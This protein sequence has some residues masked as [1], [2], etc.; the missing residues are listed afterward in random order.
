MKI[1]VIEDDA[2]LAANLWD[3]LESR[4]HIIDAAGDG[5]SGLHLA[6]VNDYEAITLDLIL[7][8]LDGLEL[9]RRLRVDARNCTPVLM[10][11]ARDT[12][13]DKLRGFEAGADDYLVKPF[14]LKELEARLTALA[15]RAN[16]D[17]GV[18]L[19]QAAD[20]TF[21]LDTLLVERAGQSIT[22]T[23]TCLQ[24]LEVL[25]RRS[26]CVVPRGELEMALWGDQPPN[27]DALSYHI[28]ALRRAIDTPFDGHLL[29]TVRG[30]GYRLS[31]A[32]TIQT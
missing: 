21:D 13:G 17:A 25:M 29:Q 2:D 22:L 20:L 28:H 10:L 15:R 4:G 18:R 7:P 30:I 6:T 1:L 26:G 11:T 14:A 9:C 12:L 23:P 27:S 3:Y 24:I 8:R 32:E 5:V 16:P 31:S 19:L